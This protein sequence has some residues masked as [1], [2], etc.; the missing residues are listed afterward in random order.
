MHLQRAFLL[1]L[2]KSLFSG[3][4]TKQKKKQKRS[5]L[6]ILK[7]CAIE[8]EFTL[9]LDIW[10]RSSSK[11]PLLRKFMSIFSREFQVFLLRDGTHA[12][13][14]EYLGLLTNASTKVPNPAPVVCRS[15][16]SRIFS[17]KG[18]QMPSESRVLRFPMMCRSKY[19]DSFQ[20]EI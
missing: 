15:S 9:L 13:N 3:I 7:S 2:K 14:F 1:Y 16:V 19:H 4:I 12:L 20:T 5:Y 6:N 11:S 8:T 10:H 18:L 17:F